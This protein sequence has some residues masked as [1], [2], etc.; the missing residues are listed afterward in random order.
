MAAAAITSRTLDHLFCLA[1]AALG[2]LVLAGGCAS[3][4]LTAPTPSASRDVVAPGTTGT[5]VQA[6][7]SQ[8]A[9]GTVKYVLTW[10]GQD[11]DVTFAGTANL[12][13]D[14]KLHRD[15][16]A[17]NDNG[18]SWSLTYMATVT[19][20]SSYTGECKSVNSFAGGGHF[21]VMDARNLSAS[22]SLSETPPVLGFVV[23][24]Y[25]L[26]DVAS[27]GGE[28][29]PKGTSTMSSLDDI[30]VPSTDKKPYQGIPATV[31]QGTPRSWDLAWSDAW[32]DT[33]MCDQQ[34]S[35]CGIHYS[36]SSSGTVTEGTASP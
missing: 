31:S 28:D 30:Y 22:V 12:T 19:R 24:N 18:G 11:G 2:A 1:A 13:M 27:G 4:G 7:G 14:L 21:G 16:Q 6:V 20:P 8:G 23:K 29:C 35:G 3:A 25:E 26:A 5:P 33:S 34:S 15:G 36:A 9:A 17:W 10:A 32:D